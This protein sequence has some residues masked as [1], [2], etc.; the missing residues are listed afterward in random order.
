MIGYRGQDLTES[1]TITIGPIKEEFTTATL[2]RVRFNQVVG[3]ANLAFVNGLLI[4]VVTVVAAHSV[5]GGPVNP[6]AKSLLNDGTVDL[7]DNPVLIDDIV[8]FKQVEL[9]RPRLGLAVKMEF[10]DNRI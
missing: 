7:L 5:F 6:R 1:L 9:G 4:L 8:E 3:R 10:W 2:T